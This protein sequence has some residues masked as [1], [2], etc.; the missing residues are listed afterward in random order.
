MPV[1]A[2]FSVMP[3]D[4]CSIYSKDLIGIAERVRTAPPEYAMVCRY[5]SGVLPIHRTLDR[6]KKGRF[7]EAAHTTLND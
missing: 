5:L 3:L 7:W 4:Y 2:L 1:A 6:A